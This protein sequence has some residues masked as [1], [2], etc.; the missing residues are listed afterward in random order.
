[1]LRQSHLVADLLAGTDLPV[2]APV[3]M[4]SDDPRKGLGEA[5]EEDLLAFQLRRI[6]ARAPAASVDLVSPY[7]VPTDTGVGV[8]QRLAAQGV[9]VRI[10]TNGLEATDVSA[11]HSGYARH[12]KALLGA[13]I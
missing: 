1:A 7:F 12:R 13:G 2:W 3:E 6:L 11:V 10:L 9:R 5:R 4:V 8:F